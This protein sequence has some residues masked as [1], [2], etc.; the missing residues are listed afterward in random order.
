MAL[1]PGS[2]EL[3]IYRGSTFRTPL[4]LYSGQATTTLSG[5]NPLNLTGFTGECIF[6]TAPNVDPPILCLS[7]ANGGIVIQTPPASGVLQLYINAQET[8]AFSWPSAVYDLFLTDNNGNYLTAGDTQA[9]I[10]GQ[11][12]VQGN[13]P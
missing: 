2:L 3:T 10:K 9:F 12:K 13:S 6:R 1:L 7:T 11:I 4:A 5:L 8:R